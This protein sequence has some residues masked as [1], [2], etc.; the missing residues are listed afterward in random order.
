[1]T[2][3]NKNLA[4][5]KFNFTSISSKLKDDSFDNLS[6]SF[7]NLCFIITFSARDKP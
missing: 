4:F 3:E 5:A 2:T 7:Y 1:M 6:A